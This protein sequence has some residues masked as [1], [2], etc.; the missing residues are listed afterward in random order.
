M[1]SGAFEAGLQPEFVL[2]DEVYGGDS[3]LR[4]F[5]ENRKQPFVVA[6]KCGQHLWAGFRQGTQVT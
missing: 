2:A 4:R 3:K 6:V 5:L 1:L